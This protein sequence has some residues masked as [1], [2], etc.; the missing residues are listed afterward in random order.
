MPYRGKNLFSRL[1]GSE[2]FI[3]VAT[4]NDTRERVNM[5]FPLYSDVYNA[6]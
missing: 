6:L 4:G 3:D 2:V 5:H 1:K